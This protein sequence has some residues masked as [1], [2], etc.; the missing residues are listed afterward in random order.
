ME[1]I[2]NQVTTQTS[3]TNQENSN[4]QNDKPVG[5][6]LSFI[7][8]MEK[9][10]RLERE[11]LEKAKRELDERGSKYSHYDELDSLLEKDPL[12]ALKKK[13][14]DYQKLSEHAMSK[15]TDEELDP[16]QRELKDLRGFKESVPE[17]IQKAIAEAI[18]GETKK[19]EA[20]SIEQE[21]KSI[22]NSIAEIIKADSNKYGVLGLEGEKGVDL[23]FE[24]L[25]KHVQDQKDQDIPEEEI[26]MMSFAEAA[27]KVE[28][29]LDS[30]LQRYLALE[31]YKTKL[32]PDQGDIN[33]S[34]SNLLKTISDDFAPRTAV[35]SESEEDRVNKAIELIKRGGLS[36]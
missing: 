24:T 34:A 8:R 12:E 15:I 1:G 5:D 18:E 17:M 7:A 14:W 3:Q 22:R 30:Q 27:E 11:E 19:H 13:G 10:L 4:V 23:V 21:T 20:Y 31:K 9:K 35:V 25:R 29:H 32:N 2:Q 28:A 16:V 36:A 26:K 6:Q 33:K